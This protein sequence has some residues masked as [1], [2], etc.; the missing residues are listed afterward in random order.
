MKSRI[1]KISA[2]IIGL[3]LCNLNFAYCY[4]NVRVVSSVADLKNIAGLSD[5]LYVY[6]PGYRQR[7]DGGGGMFRWD[8]TSVLADNGGTVLASNESSTGRWLRVKTGQRDINVKWFGA[9]GD[10]VHD[11]AEAIQAAAEQAKAESAS[12]YLPKG[13]YQC[14]TSLNFTNWDGFFIKGEGTGGWPQ[15]NIS[16]CKLRFD[17]GVD[18]GVDFSGSSFGTVESLAFENASKT[19]VLLAKTYKSECKDNKFNDCGFSKSGVGGVFLYRADN[20]T[21]TSCRMHTGNAVPAI[22]MTGLNDYGIFSAYQNLAPEGNVSGL[23]YFGGVITA[24]NTHNGLFLFDGRAGGGMDSFSLLGSYIPMAGGNSKLYCFK[25]KGN[26]SNISF[27]G[28]R[29]EITSYEG[30][31]VAF[32]YI[33]TEAVVDGLFLISHVT[34]SESKAVTGGGTLLNSYIQNFNG[35]I[36]LAGDVINSQIISDYV[37]DMTVAVGG[38]AKGCRFVSRDTVTASVDGE[39]LSSIA[40][41]T[42]GEITNIVHYETVNGFNTTSSFTLTPNGS[43]FAEYAGDVYWVYTYDVGGGSTATTVIQQ[44]EHPNGGNLSLTDNTV[45]ATYT[46][47]DDVF[48]IRKL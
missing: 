1:N 22:V 27:I 16:V 35:S 19:Q 43:Y 5:G 38:D 47:V 7:D 34:N 21:F 36:D 3:L 46:G 6:L 37:G 29:S 31:D 48:I 45:T 10:A 24:D 40:V 33:D 32:G 20:T 4:E 17:P 44:S 39:L 30:S 9:Y 11:D 15:S 25:A 42:K 13:I 26:C 41:P 8:S 23:N 14:N 2:L 28:P 12:L 18:V